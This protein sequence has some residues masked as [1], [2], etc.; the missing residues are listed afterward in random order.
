MSDVLTRDSGAFQ[1]YEPKLFLY[2]EN[3][4]YKWQVSGP[5]SLKDSHGLVVTPADCSLRQILASIDTAIKT[6]TKQ[7]NF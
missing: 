7:K 2:L 5:C 6:K 4:L 1:N 3:H